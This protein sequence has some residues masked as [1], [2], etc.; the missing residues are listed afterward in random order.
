M[1]SMHLKPLRAGEAEFKYNSEDTQI[2]SPRKTVCA[3]VKKFALEQTTAH[4][5][6]NIFRATTLFG[7]LLWTVLF[8]AGVVATFYQGTVLVLKFRRYPVNVEVK[9]VTKALLE[10]PSVTVCNTNK[11]RTSAIEK[12]KHR[13]MLV[14]DQTTSLPYYEPCLDDDFACKKRPVCIKRY[15]LCDA[16]RQCGVNDTSDERDCNYGKF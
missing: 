8:L 9:I 12:S 2:E 1:D 11:L 5:F 15:L 7:R 14:V 13:R 10:L 6:P 4:G 3:T 16:I